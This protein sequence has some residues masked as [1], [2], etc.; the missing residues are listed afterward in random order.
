MRVNRSNSGT[1]TVGCNY[2]IACAQIEDRT[3][4]T[5]YVAGTRSNTQALVDLVG[6]TSLTANLTYAS[7]GSFAFDGASNYMRPTAPHSYLLSSSCECVFRI[8]TLPAA[9]K[10]S[11]IFGYS[12]QN[13]YSEAGAGLTYLNSSGKI[14]GSLITTSQVYRQVLSTATIATNT[15]YHM[16]FNK[17]VSTGVMDLY[18]NGKLDSTQTFDQ[19]TYAFWAGA[20]INVTTLDI[21]QTANA[22]QATW[23]PSY[24]DGDIPT[25]KL[26]SRTLTAAEVMQNFNAARGRYGI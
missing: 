13:G 15:Y 25:C 11:T 17:N 22:A 1:N 21:G 5:P 7:N 2:D 6:A 26:Y 16:V 4:A 23:V 19:A 9:G 10:Y 20:F 8:R 14:I 12:G 3:F 24:F 18:I